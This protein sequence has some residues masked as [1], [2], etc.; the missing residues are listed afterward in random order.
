MNG[1]A[2]RWNL[3]EYILSNAN[4]RRGSSETLTFDGSGGNRAFIS[5]LYCSVI[6]RDVASLMGW[7]SV[8]GSVVLMCVTF[9]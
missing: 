6:R 5:A 2:I 7:K 9:L 4:A 8:I 3:V 1:S